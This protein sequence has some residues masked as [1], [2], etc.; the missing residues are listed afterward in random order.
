MMTLDNYNF[1][2]LKMI[3]VIYNFWMKEVMCGMPHKLT[4]LCAFQWH[5]SKTFSKIKTNDTSSNHMGVDILTCTINNPNH[6]LIFWT[7]DYKI[8]IIINKFFNINYYC[9]YIMY[10]S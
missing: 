10:I 9:E 4:I 8:I 6:Y 2:V 3:N 1:I 5:L 7:L